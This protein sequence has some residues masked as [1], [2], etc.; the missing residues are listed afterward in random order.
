MSELDEF[1]K[2]NRENAITD[3]EE[4][5]RIIRTTADLNAPPYR[6][7][8]LF[9]PKTKTILLQGNQAGLEHLLG[10]IEI[11]AASNTESG[12]HFHYDSGNGLSK[13]DVNLIIQRVGDNDTGTHTI[14]K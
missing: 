4:V 3:P 10:I 13:N 9:D 1:R 8:L 6:L 7:E 12:N 14:E 5:L 11:L 2:R